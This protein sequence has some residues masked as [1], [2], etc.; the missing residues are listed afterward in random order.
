MKLSRL[1]VLSPEEITLI[2][3][4]SLNILAEVGILVESEAARELVLSHGGKLK[5]KRG[6]VTVPPE[7]VERCVKL[8]PRE[9]P[10]FDR[11]GKLAFTLGDGGMCCVSGHNAVFMLDTERGER[12]DSIVQDVERFAVISQE[13]GDATR[14]I[15]F[16]LRE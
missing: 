9:V 10:L 12:R 8:L 15:F 13:M 11:E 3:Q 6:V 7:L 16:F 4:R 2:H 5:N 14:P 1:E